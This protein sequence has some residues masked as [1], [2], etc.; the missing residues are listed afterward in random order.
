MAKLDMPLGGIKMSVAGNDV[1]GFD[2]GRKKHVF[3]SPAL[4]SG[5]DILKAQKLLYRLFH[6]QKTPGSGI[7]LIALHQGRPLPVTHGTGS[8]IGQ[9]V[10]IEENLKRKIS[11]EDIADAA[12]LS[13]WYF[14][15]LF[16]IM[17][18]YCVSDYLRR[19]RICEA[20]HELLYG[21][22]PILQLAGEYQFE[23]Q[24]AFTRSF[25]SIT[26]ISPGRFRKLLPPILRFPALSLDNSY[27]HL[28]K[29]AKM[30]NPRI[31]TM[32]A[33]TVVGV[34]CTSTPSETLHKLWGD[35]MQRH[36]EIK[37]VKDASKAYQVCVFDHSDPAR[38]EYTFIAGM[39]VSD[40]SDVPEGMMAHAVPAA[41]YAVFEHHGPMDRMHQSYEYIFGVWLPENAYQ[42]ADADSLEIYDER[43]K[44]ES[45]DSIFEIWIPVKKA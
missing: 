39:E 41:E 7:A 42:M 20:S 12:N 30:L 14:H 11:L 15:R 34:H 13:Q 35:F 1:P 5:Q 29:G 21:S 26:G 33:F 9:K 23:S 37:H 17:T 22:K 19:R 10:Y 45:P 3:G 40:T 4:M 32:A 24:E 25:G 27:N 8:R 16:R 2:E 31:E 44:P 6:P 38:E 36:T 18:G 28:K 43:F